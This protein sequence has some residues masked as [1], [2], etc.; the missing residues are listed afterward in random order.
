MEG[1]DE[2]SPR[3]KL[4]LSKPT[5]MQD[6]QSVPGVDTNNLPQGGSELRRAAHAEYAVSKRTRL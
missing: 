5:T 3:T 4:Q 1:M 2:E 6:T